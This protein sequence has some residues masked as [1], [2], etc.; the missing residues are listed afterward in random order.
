MI[1]VPD[2]VPSTSFDGSTVIEGKVDIYKPSA[3]DL[4]ADKVDDVADVVAK[5]LEAPSAITHVADHGLAQGHDNSVGSSMGSSS[6]D[7]SSAS[8]DGNDLAPAGEVGASKPSM[9]DV[10]AGEAA[11]IDLVAIPPEA[12]SMTTHVA[13]S[14]HV[15]ANKARYVVVSGMSVPHE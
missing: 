2:E 10:S 15:P 6:R 3:S 13:S 7:Q 11:Y 9:G 5:A 14:A 12:L 1:S 8:I 4:S